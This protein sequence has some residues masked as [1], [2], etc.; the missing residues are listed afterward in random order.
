MK[1][2]VI[3]ILLLLIGLHAQGQSFLAPSDTLNKRRV[4]GVTATT[5]VLWGGSIAALQ[6]VWYNEFDKS[7]FHFFND[8][9][10]WNQMDKVGHLYTSFHFSGAVDDFY[11]WSGVEHKKSAIISAAYS[12]GYMATFEILDAYNEKWGFSLSDLG[13]NAL[14]TATYF[15]QAYF[16]DKQYVHLKFSAHESG[17]A[18]Y[19]PTVLGADFASRLLKDYNG[20]TYWASFNP[21]YWG[22]TKSKVPEWL[23]LSLGYSINNQLIGNGGTYIVQSGTNQQIFTPYRQ[24]FLSLDVDFQ[25]IPTKS[26]LLKLL[27]RGLNIIKVPFPAVELSNGKVQLHG[28]YF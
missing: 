6:F 10:E 25:A 18:D 23:N 7:K 26:R 8:S 16:W 15:S 9:K 21:F 12:F 4:I 24:Y 3:P 1:R 22:N 5:S 20:Q 28:L 11:K 2:G 19:R 17:L 13:F 14:G 27:F